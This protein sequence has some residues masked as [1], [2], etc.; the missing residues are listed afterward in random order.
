MK[1]NL[2]GEYLLDQRGVD[3]SNGTAVMGDRH[4]GQSARDWAQSGQVAWWPQGAK[5]GCGFYV[6]HG[7]LYI[8]RNTL[9][10]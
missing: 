6:V 2:Q 1:G 8:D 5:Y 10:L 9:F 4:M 7:D 3:T